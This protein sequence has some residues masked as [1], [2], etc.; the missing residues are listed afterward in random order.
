MRSTLRVGVCEIYLF[1][2]DE[3]RLERVAWDRG[4]GDEP[5]VSSEELLRYAVGQPA[6]VIERADGTTH[7]ASPSLPRIDKILESEGARAVIVPLEIRGRTVGILR[8]AG[9]RLALDHEN[10]RF[11]SILSY[12]AAL[13]VERVR[14]TGQAERAEAL[15][16]ADRLKDS[17]IA[18]VSH[19]LRTPLTTIKALARELRGENEGLVV[20]EEEADRLNRIV[21][22]LLDLSR[23][24]ANALRLNIELNAAEDLLGAALGRISAIPGASEIQASVDTASGIIVGRFDFVHSLRAMTNLLENALRHRGDGAIE[25]Q[26]RRVGDRVVFDVLD[27]GRGI[28]PE[29]AA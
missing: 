29:D 5:P 2:P 22:D 21:E 19:D 6:V 18:S 3:A 27:R 28:P 9:E 1:V 13:G 7:L 10:A 17:F 12:Y 16:E 14:L 4:E 25:V 24:R 8:V 11:A 23:I 15:Q 26:A 20:I